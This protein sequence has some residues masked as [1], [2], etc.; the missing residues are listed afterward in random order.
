M[1]L[2][3]KYIGSGPCGFRLYF[4]LFFTIYV[5]VE[6]MTHVTPGAWA[7]FGHRTIT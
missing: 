3:T 4:F 5:N 7:I 6:H 2:H 1:L